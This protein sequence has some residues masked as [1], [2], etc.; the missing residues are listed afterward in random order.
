MRKNRNLLLPLLI[1]ITIASCRTTSTNPTNVVDKVEELDFKNV[2]QLEISD[3]QEKADSTLHTFEGFGRTM[4]IEDYL[5]ADSIIH[6]PNDTFDGF[7]PVS[8]AH[9]ISFLY[10]FY[11]NDFNEDF[12]KIILINLEYI[13]KQLTHAYYAEYKFSHNHF[14]VPMG[15]VW[16]SGMAQGELLGAFCRGF[17]LTNDSHY[18]NVAN[19][20]FETLITNTDP[21]WCVHIDDNDY[22]WIEEYP[23]KE[24][25]HVLNGKLYALWGIWEYYAITRDEKA[26]L[27]FQAG[28]KSVIDNFDE[29]WLASD[30]PR[31]MYCSHSLASVNYHNLHIHQFKF[32]NNYLHLSEFE[33][34]IRKLESKPLL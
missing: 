9:A 12:K 27:I 2:K 20:L 6:T 32:M 14:G 19:S 10:D 29:Y 31:S 18:L 8:H 3:I 26:R 11:R 1:L 25:C 23:N 17:I 5:D 22:Y 21:Y 4:V 28:I 16:V 30:Q 15:D 33:E 24:H 7:H 34:I 13:E